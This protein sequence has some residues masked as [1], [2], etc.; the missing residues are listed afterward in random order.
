MTSSSVSSSLVKAV[1]TDRRNH[2]PN[3]LL[4]RRQVVRAV[5]EGTGG[6]GPVEGPEEGVEGVREDE[7]LPVPHL[8]VLS[9]VQTSRQQ[10]HH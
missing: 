8:H 10:Q 9:L 4:E 2:S 3:F 5:E 7:G 6:G 1:T